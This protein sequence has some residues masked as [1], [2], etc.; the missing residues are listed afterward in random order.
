MFFDNKYQPHIVISPQ[1]EQKVSFNTIARSYFNQDATLILY[2]LITDIKLFCRNKVDHHGSFQ[3]LPST[4]GDRSDIWV[5]NGPNK[6]QSY[7]ITFDLLMGVLT[8]KLL[9]GNPDNSV[10][11]FCHLD[12]KE[13]HVRGRGFEGDPPIRPWCASRGRCLSLVH[14]AAGIKP[15]WRPRLLYTQVAFVSLS[16][17]IFVP[18]RN[19]REE[20][21]LLSRYMEKTTPSHEGSFE[22]W[23]VDVS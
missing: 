4:L 14:E 9:Q 2:G 19:H 6:F 5:L 15:S 11:Y 17:S 22:A 7:R 13:G 12:A 10:V 3:A 23:R 16:S 8:K 18:S 21:R 1:Y 20:T